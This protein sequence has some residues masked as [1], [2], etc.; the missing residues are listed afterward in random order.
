NKNPRPLHIS[1]V[2]WYAWAAG[3][4]YALALALR[5]SWLAAGGAALLF[6]VHPAHV[7]VVAWISSRKDLLALRFAALATI[8][9][10]FYRRRPARTWAWYLGSLL[11]FFLASASK[12][13]VVLLPAFFL[14][15]DF[16]VEKRRHPS[17]LFDKVPFGLMT[18]FFAWKTLQ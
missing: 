1:N 9:Y 3:T 14:L 17:M 12:Q 7:E 5:F 15:W 2:F 8:C 16:L 18:L 6:L 11:C 10:L 13:S 4:V